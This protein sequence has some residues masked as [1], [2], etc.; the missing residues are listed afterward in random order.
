MGRME[1]GVPEVELQRDPALFGRLARWRLHFLP[2]CYFHGSELPYLANKE[3]TPEPRI[4]P[5]FQK[6]CE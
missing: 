4:S 1:A 3:L 5:E 6:A 2:A